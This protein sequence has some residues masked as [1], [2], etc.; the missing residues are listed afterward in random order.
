MLGPKSVALL[1]FQ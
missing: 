1:E